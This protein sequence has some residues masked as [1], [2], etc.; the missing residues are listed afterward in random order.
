MPL[1]L[2]CHRLVQGWNSD[3]IAK[4][5]AELGLV[6]DQCLRLMAVCVAVSAAFSCQGVP[7]RRKVLQHFIFGIFLLRASS[8][9]GG[10]SLSLSCYSQLQTPEGVEVRGLRRLR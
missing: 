1:S 10:Q 3:M 5:L 9:P 7:A 4:D 2:A 6:L 8:H